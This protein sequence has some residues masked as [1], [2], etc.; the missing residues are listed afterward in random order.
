ME[1]VAFYPII[2]FTKA[3]VFRIHWIIAEE[4]PLSF[5][6]ETTLNNTIVLVD[7]K[8]SGDHRPLKCVVVGMPPPTVF[9]YKVHNESTFHSIT[10][11]LIMFEFRTVI[12]QN[13]SWRIIP[14]RTMMANTGY[15][16]TTRPLKYIISHGLQTW[17]SRVSLITGEKESR[18]TRTSTLMVIHRVLLSWTHP[19]QCDNCEPTEVE[20]EFVLLLFFF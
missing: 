19:G 14:M 16:L 13:S 15:Q 1:T 10:M 20:Q 8:H 4:S 17:T 2:R 18:D 12:G 9:W 11:Q 3:Y 5:A 7:A 6:E